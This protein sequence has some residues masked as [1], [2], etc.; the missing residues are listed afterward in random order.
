MNICIKNTYP[1]GPE[2]SSDFAK[3][4]L[5][6]IA[7]NLKYS[8]IIKKLQMEDD[9]VNK[10]ALIVSYVLWPFVCI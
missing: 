6:L 9:Y 5:I 4:A 8:D 7:K 2:K 10:L 1:D 3:A